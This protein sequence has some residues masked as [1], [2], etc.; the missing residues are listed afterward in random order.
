MLASSRHRRDETHTKSKDVKAK[1]IL[2]N[3]AAAAAL[4]LF[5]GH[6]VHLE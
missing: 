3:L 4:G 5:A 1:I 6:A 2:A